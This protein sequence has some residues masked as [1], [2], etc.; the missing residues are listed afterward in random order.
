MQKSER[1]VARRR[2]ARR[3]DARD[4]WKHRNL[5]GGSG[6]GG[7]EG[8]GEEEEEEEEGRV[9]KGR[10]A[11]ERARLLAKR[12][13]RGWLGGTQGSRQGVGSH[14]QAGWGGVKGENAKRRR[15]PRSI[16]KR[17]RKRLHFV[18]RTSPRRF[19]F[20]K[21][22]DRSLARTTSVTGPLEVVTC[23][24]GALSTLPAGRRNHSGKRGRDAALRSLACHYP[25]SNPTPGDFD[26]GRRKTSRLE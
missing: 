24:R 9:E 10:R 15:G 21:M 20:S 11:R 25:F 17:R 8:A 16:P 2:V 23:R 12:D 1:Q 6:G 22:A 18:F 7:R 4:G 13:V 5:A 14:G 19:R 3:W 26:T